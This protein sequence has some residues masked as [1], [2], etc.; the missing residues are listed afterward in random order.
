MNTKSK[1]TQRV[2]HS[3]MPCVAVL[4]ALAIVS[5]E[6]RAQSGAHAEHHAAR[7]APSATV[8][9]VTRAGDTLY[10]L[11]DRYLADAR[12]WA[13]LAR[14]NRIA[15]PRALR[16]G[17]VL[18]LP[19]AAL[20]QERQVARVVA[21]S[22][23]AEHAFRAEP[24][25][26]VTVDMALV[27]GDRVRTGANGFVSLELAD[28]SH[29][30]LPQNSEIEI[31]TLRRTAIVGSTDRVIRLK[32]GQVD[33]EVTPAK[34]QDDRFQIRSPSVVAG[35]RGTRFRV[36]YD[37]SQQQTAVEVLDGAVGVDKDTMDRQAP[38]R[39]VPLGASAQLVR[40]KFGN[41]THA[42]GSVGAP[43]EL[44]PA[45]ALNHPAKIQDAD[46]VAFD[47]TSTDARAL[48]WRVQIA[49]DAGILDLIRDTQVT[50]PHASF[51]ALA[52]GT[53]FVRISAIDANGLEGI[54]QTYAFERRKM[55]LD[56]SA[57]PVGERHAYAFRWF[58][59]RSNPDT[60]FRFVLASTPDLANPLVDRTDLSGGQLT[61]SDLPRGVYY[62]TVI[63]EQFEHGRFYAKS[64]AVRSFTLA[65]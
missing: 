32:Q 33:S 38:A 7:H 21:T 8:R 62:W 19:V 30:S 22:G 58:V 54:P 56:A 36:D 64:S 34:K 9:Y 52:D 2:L 42:G 39:G 50:S 37:G 11:A 53:Y 27:E 13:L 28:G 20:K 35:V 41:V 59:T 47:L 31:G 60:R 43:V 61:V 25:A 65:Y 15:E 17:T 6:A 55:G 1:R 48:A 26:P 5:G 23:V 57:A 14:V 46:D 40:A 12:D 24:F 29:V 45:P 16:P 10:D 3:A 63:A 44:L 49:R 51:G 18:R 4:G